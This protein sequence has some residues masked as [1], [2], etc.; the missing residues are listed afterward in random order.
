MNKFATQQLALETHVNAG[1]AANA[2]NA[3][4]GQNTAKAN[5]SVGNGKHE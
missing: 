4:N 1:S 3:G 5:R 2:A